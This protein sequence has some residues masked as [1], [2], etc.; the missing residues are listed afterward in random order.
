MG[1]VDKWAGFPLQSLNNESK[2]MRKGKGPWYPWSPY[3]VER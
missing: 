3:G 1:L 2:K